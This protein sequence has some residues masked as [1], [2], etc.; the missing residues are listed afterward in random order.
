MALN[1]NSFRARAATIERIEEVITPSGAPHNTYHLKD[2]PA[3]MSK[4]YGWL[5]VVKEGK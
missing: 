5:E 2:P 1:P 3:E 4:H